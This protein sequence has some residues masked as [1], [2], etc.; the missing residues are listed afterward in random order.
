MTERQ[1]LDAVVDVARLHGWSSVHFGGDR[2]GRA[3][4]DATGF[5]DLLLV[6]ADRGLVWFRELKTAKGRM[7]GAQR[8][9][10]DYLAAGG[11]NVAIWRPDDFADIVAALSF[12]TA[13]V[14]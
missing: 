12:G 8:R 9:W 2:H 13:R 10:Y 3:W 4:Y 7:S 11:F 14:A 5:P 6:N 1:L